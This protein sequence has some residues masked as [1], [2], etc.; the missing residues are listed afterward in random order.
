[1]EGSSIAITPQAPAYPYQPQAPICPYP[2]QEP[3]CPYPTQAPPP[4][5][6]TLPSAPP[7]PYGIAP[8]ASGFGVPA[9]GIVMPAPGIVMPAPGIVMPAPGAGIPAQ[10]GVPVGGIQQMPTANQIHGQPLLISQPLPPNNPYPLT[11]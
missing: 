8:P 10:Y 4:Y 2:P 9:P 5:A 7:A 6:S 1:M 3:F 11:C